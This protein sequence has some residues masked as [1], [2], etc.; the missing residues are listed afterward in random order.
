MNT[1][2]KIL[3]AAEFIRSRVNM[4]PTVGL[5]LGSGLGD[6]TDTLEDVT[7]IPYS[8]IPNFPVPTIAGH[9][10]ALVFSARSSSD[11][12]RQVPA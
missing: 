1:T 3:A 9:A 7:R 4:E 5:V 12:L 2:E 10:G 6:Y 11:K 8:E